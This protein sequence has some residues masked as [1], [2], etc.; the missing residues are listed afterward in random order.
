MRF[1]VVEGTD[2]MQDFSAAYTVLSAMP[3]TCSQHNSLGSSVSQLDMQF[4]L[5]NQ[6]GLFTVYLLLGLVLPYHSS[7]AT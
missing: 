6:R 5:W 1:S 4:V 2:L 3:L 7:F